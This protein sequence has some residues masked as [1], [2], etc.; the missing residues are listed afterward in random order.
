MANKNSIIDLEDLLGLKDFDKHTLE[1]DL[2]LMINDSKEGK[3]DLNVGD[4]VRCQYE[5]TGQ[6][7]GVQNII[8]RFGYTLLDNGNPQL[9]GKIRK[10]KAIT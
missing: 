8:G 6:F 7:A 2:Q 9:A 4:N 3:L 10:Y 5:L 1:Y